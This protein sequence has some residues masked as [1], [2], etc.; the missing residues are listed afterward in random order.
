MG[1][2][3]YLEDIVDRLTEDL[4][5]C[6]KRVDDDDGAQLADVRQRLC[7]FQETAQQVVNE[8]RDLLQVA[9][10]PSFDVAK[11]LGL[12][13]RD[14]ARAQRDLGKATDELRL[15]RPLRDFARMRGAYDQKLRAAR[16]QC[17]GLESDSERLLKD[18][19]KLR[20]ENRALGIQLRIARERLESVQRAKAG[21]SA[22]S[23]AEP[24]FNLQRAA[25]EVIATAQGSQELE[26]ELVSLVA[27]SDEEMDLLIESGGD[28]RESK[29]Q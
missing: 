9:T 19:S 2:A 7:A 8:A 3:S 28:E 11:E 13:R 15:L 10:D 17:K 14:L 21:S 6:S 26:R 18:N 12:C 29:R 20:R 16:R 23:R 4:L 27:M 25:Q 22:P 1:Y 24:A 5:E